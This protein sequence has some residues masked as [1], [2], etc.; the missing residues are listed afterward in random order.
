MGIGPSIPRREPRIRTV[1]DPR[2][3]RRPGRLRRVRRARPER[4]AARRRRRGSSVRPCCSRGRTMRWFARHALLAAR[5]SSSPP[6]SRTSA[7]RAFAGGAAAAGADVRKNAF[8]PYTNER[9]GVQRRGR[10]RNAHA[11][12]PFRGSRETTRGVPVLLRQR[13]RRGLP[14]R[15]ARP[16]RRSPCLEKSSIRL[17]RRRYPLHQPWDHLGVAR[18]RLLG[19]PTI[20]NSAPSSPASHRSHRVL[21]DAGPAIPLLEFLDLVLDLHPRLHR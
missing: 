6:L 14:P 2:P 15:Q 13:G 16:L 4:P 7:P 12:G 10:V 17:V 9:F 20:R 5:N 1:F 11:R 21:V 19:A 18:G 8:V 3:A